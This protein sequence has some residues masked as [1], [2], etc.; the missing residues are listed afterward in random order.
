MG[1]VRGPSSL[2]FE[3]N[4]YSSLESL[5]LKQLGLVMSL[6]EANMGLIL[7]I[8]GRHRRE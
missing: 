2:I 7:G 3:D 6:Y 4:S 8:V 1:N 5:D